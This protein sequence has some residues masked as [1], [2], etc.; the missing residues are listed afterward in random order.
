MVFSCY[1]SITS[2]VYNPVMNQAVQDSK[3]LI[4]TRRNSKRLLTNSLTY[5]GSKLQ[6][7]TQIIT[8]SLTNA[9]TQT[10]RLLRPP[11]VPGSTHSSNC[12]SVEIDLKRKISPIKFVTKRSIFSTGNFSSNSLFPS[13]TDFLFRVMHQLPKKVHDFLS[14]PGKMIKK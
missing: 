9:A 6:F 14:Q 10:A 3:V 4:G 1:N 7:A 13:C 2:L 8:F 11:R 12:S 5:R